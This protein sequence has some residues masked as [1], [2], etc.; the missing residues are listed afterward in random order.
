MKIAIAI[1]AVAAV[2][3]VGYLVLRKP[4]QPA[5]QQP[6]AAAPGPSGYATG[7]NSTAN[8]VSQW[9]GVAQQGEQ[10]FGSGYSQYQKMNG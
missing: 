2:C 4:K 5:P 1:V 6:P 8:T 7:G 9:L 3:G 10:L